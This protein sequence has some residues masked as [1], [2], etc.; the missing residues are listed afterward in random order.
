[1]SACSF[2]IPFTKPVNE[3]LQKA[4]ETVESQEGTFTGNET[5]GN[6]DVSVFGNTIVGNYTV[7]G[8]ELTIYISDKPFLVPCN[9]I[10]SFLSSKL[11]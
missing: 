9:M 5:E 8:N 10:E 7:A 11:N 4:K 3:I 1:M 2:T 6:F